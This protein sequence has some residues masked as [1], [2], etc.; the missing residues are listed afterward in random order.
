MK[1]KIM[2]GAVL[3]AF[4]GC[5]ADSARADDDLY[6][7]YLWS[8]FF[9]AG[10]R[11][12]AIADSGDFPVVLTDVASQRQLGL[13]EANYGPYAGEETLKN[14]CFYYGD[15]GGLLSVSD[16]FLGRYRAGGFTLDTLCMALVSGITHDPETG[17]RLATVQMAN[18][19][20]LSQPDYL[21][22]PG[23]LSQ[24]YPV[25]IPACFRN[26]AP[27]SDC[28]FNFDPWSG[29][30]LTAEEAGRV[31]A[32][33][34]RITER[35]Q[36]LLAAGKFAKP[37]APGANADFDDSCFSDVESPSGYR[38][39]AYN[40]GAV[41]PDLLPL[42]G[43]YVFSDAYALGFAYSIGADGAAGPSASMESVR[44]AVSGKNRA[45]SARL[46]TLQVV[47]SAK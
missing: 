22:E 15:G 30:R 42:N 44:L 9:E 12:P 13:M 11:G 35:L 7:G 34:A 3:L 47:A 24:E 1:F 25:E 31:A 17:A 39:R 28:A 20:Q 14:K 8:V 2:A 19:E 5:G 38:G 6:E 18:V 21:G 37:C 45:T 10:A 36:A 27:L 29:A 33:G 23:P 26:G 40:V 4:T 46:K 16:E 43:F 41:Y 32:A